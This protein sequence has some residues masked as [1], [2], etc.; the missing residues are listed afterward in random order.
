[1]GEFRNAKYLTKAAP[2]GVQN[3]ARQ[4]AEASLQRLRNWDISDDQIERLTREATLTRTLTLHSSTDGVVLEKMPVAGVRELVLRVVV[5]DS[6]VTVT[7][8]ANAI[9]A[10]AGNSLTQI[11]R[12]LRAR[13]PAEDNFDADSESIILSVPVRLRLRGGIK[14]VEG[15]DQSNW[16]VANARHDPVLI[17]AL[18]Q[19]HEWRGWIEEGSAVLLEDVSTR[20]SHDRKYSHKILKLAFLA[21]TSSGPS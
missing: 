11:V 20:S 8:N 3:S 16:T 13:L 12:T 6:R 7:F 9:V 14:R 5:G 1:M 10:L 17:K 4:L 19:A 21:P 18:A 15:W 2:A